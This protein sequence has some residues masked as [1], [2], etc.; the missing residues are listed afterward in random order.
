MGRYL[1]KRLISNLL[2]LFLIISI[3]FFLM[4]AIPGDPFTS[5][6]ALPKEILD[7]L[8]DHYHLDDPWYTQY[9]HYLK[10]VVSLDLGPSFKYKGRT[11]NE[12]IQSGFPVSATL[13]IEA[14]LISLSLGL[15]FGT[16][17][18]LKRNHWQ[19]YLSMIFS[20]LGISVPS[21][22]MA[23][24]LQYLLA[25]KLDL[26][27]VARWGSFSQSILPA[28][29]LAA[30]PTAFIARLI[31]ASMV[32]VLTMDYI[33]TARSKGLFERQVIFGHALRNAILPVITYLGTLTTNILTGSFVIE[34]IF[35]IPGLG[36]W[37]VNSIANRDYT[38]IMG[39]T[40]FYGFLM[41]STIFLVDIL[42]SFIDPRIKMG[43]KSA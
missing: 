19:D 5:E 21:F 7:S 29:S 36:Q 1:F 9:G 6:K 23:A 42:Y 34:K 26:F 11:V 12:I 28:I 22:I 14:L 10:S 41:L 18:A 31:R 4:K 27:P 30:L 3:T 16:L 32:E 39:I 20:V 24:F 40:V 38:V 17:A 35:G 43:A 8:R 25:I 15:L 37:F 33:K 13:G 2:A